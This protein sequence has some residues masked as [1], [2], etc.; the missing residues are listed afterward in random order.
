MTVEPLKAFR[1]EIP[2]CELVALVD[3]STAMVLAWDSIVK[4]PQEQVDALSAQ[5]AA[6]LSGS[7]SEAGATLLDRAVLARDTGCFTFQRASRGSSEVLCCVY[8]PGTDLSGVFERVTA[9]C[10]IVLGSDILPRASN[11]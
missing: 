1:K 10:D 4:W 7:A 9:L 8:A 5:A 2:G 3:L 11:E 6:L